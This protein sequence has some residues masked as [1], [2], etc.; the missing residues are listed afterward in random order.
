MRQNETQKLAIFYPLCPPVVTGSL[1]YVPP[2]G[3]FRDPP[4]PM[5]TPP[6]LSLGKRSYSSPGQ[7]FAAASVGGS[8]NSNSLSLDQPEKLSSSSYLFGFNAESF[9]RSLSGRALGPRSTSGAAWSGSRA[10][11]PPHSMGLK[12]VITFCLWHR[13]AGL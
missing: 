9:P 11:Y 12:E 5:Q 3:G 8:S 1:E 4:L 13:C 10:S 2:D 7:A 6:L